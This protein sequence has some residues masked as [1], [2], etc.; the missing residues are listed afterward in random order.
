MNTIPTSFSSTDDLATVLDEWTTQADAV[1]ASALAVRSAHAAYMKMTDSGEKA[2]CA[3]VLCE[4]GLA[5]ETGLGI[6][7]LNAELIS[8]QRLKAWAG[9][10]ASAAGTQTRKGQ[11]RTLKA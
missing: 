8:D 9:A 3:T 4:H 6:V 1:L 11:L 5:L 7:Y 2:E 10:A